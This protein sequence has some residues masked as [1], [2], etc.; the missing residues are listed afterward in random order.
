MVFPGPKKPCGA[1]ISLYHKDLLYPLNST[2]PPQLQSLDLDRPFRFRYSTG[3]KPQLTTLQVTSTR[4]G[5]LAVVVEV[6]FVA[7][8]ALGLRFGAQESLNKVNQWLERP[9]PER[10]ST[11]EDGIGG[12]VEEEGGGEIQVNGG[13]GGK[14]T[15]GRGECGSSQGPSGVVPYTCFLP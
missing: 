5:N 7:A 10:G 9:D 13:G 6:R 15:R 1:P 12:N 4:P 11:V 2:I 14:K 3:V 8:I